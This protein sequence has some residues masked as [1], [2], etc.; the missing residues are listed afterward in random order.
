MDP[1]DGEVVAAATGNGGNNGFVRELLRSVDLETLAHVAVREARRQFGLTGLLLLWWTRPATPGQEPSLMLA[2]AGALTAADRAWLQ[3]HAGERRADAPIVVQELVSGVMGRVALAWPATIAPPQS[4]EWQRFVEDVAAVAGRLVELDT[5]TQAVLRLER[6]ERLQRAL[7]AIAEMASSD[8]DMPEMLRSVHEVLGELMYA[9]N[10]FIVLIE[11]EHMALRFLYFADTM[12][13]DRPGPGTLIPIASIPNSL[14]L[15]MLRSGQPQMG[16]SDDLRHKLGVDRDDA[17]GPDSV[18]WLGV[19]L[20]HY[21][22][23]R[24][25]IVVQ[26]YVEEHRFGEQ[27]RALLAYVAQHILTALDRKRAQEEMEKRVA[28]RTRELAQAN[29]ELRLEVQERQRS[30]RLQAALYR[31]AEISSTAASIEEFYAAVHGIVGQL[32]YARNFY[33]ALVSEDGRELEFPYSVDERDPVRQR[34]KLAK[35]LTEYVLRTGQ[36]LLADR[37][38]IESLGQVGE[39]QSFGSRSVY[40]LGVPLVCDECTV[41]VVAVQSYSTDISFSERDQEL[42]TFVG[43]HIANGLQ[44]QRAQDSLRSAYT[45][46]EKRVSDRT[47]ELALANRELTNEIVER[48]RIEG[49]LKHQALHDALTGLPNRSFLLDR[50][51]RALLRYRRQ[52]TRGF[53]VLFL[54]LDRFKVVNDSVGHLVGDELLKQAATRIAAEVQEPDMVARL[55][56]DEF[57]ILLDDLQ[58]PDRATCIADRI[59]GTFAEPMRIGGKEL[60]TSASIG[61]AFSHP[62]YSRAEELLRDADVAMYRAKAQGRQRFEIFDEQLRAEALRVLDLEGDLRRALARGEFEPHFQAIVR[63]GDAA[64]VGYEALLRWRHGE[65]GLLLPGDFLTVAEDNGSIEQID[66]QMFAL[67]CRDAQRLPEAHAYVSI[68]V[69]ARQLRSSDFD[70]SVLHL[71]GAH[72]LRPQRIRL[73]VTEGALLENP[74]H[75]RR[76]L[77]RLREAGVVVQL[78]DFGT[79]YSSLSYLHRFPIHSLKIDRSFVSDLR[80]GQEG[81]SAAVVRAIHALSDSLGIEV[82]GEGIETHQQCQALKD[83]GCQLGQ[84]FLFSRPLPVGEVGKVA[85][86]VH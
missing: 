41:G 26:S 51:A 57:A 62:R 54:D 23:V 81:G 38:A 20:V 25:A 56:G 66:W 55:G 74:D 64:V 37:A 63:L 84:G 77:E 72:G 79:G 2:P 47:R 75:V 83:L 71:I 7:Y 24:G 11:P 32:L 1:Q 42:L 9:E 65:R 36:A 6:A 70:Q 16:P 39:V 68:N 18:D 58:Q 49:R 31:I 17:L 46:L 69:S 80:P 76:L 35:G 60:F 10:F 19:P 28:E 40:W 44:R 52:E 78:D 29:A 53:A 59:I 13:H 34:R 27:D 73:E 8:L 43:Y 33:I 45:D 15:A 4:P 12:D 82:I 3:R 21:G 86:A 30:E 67:A 85:A 5:L 22:I 61:I 14:T 50:L 48:E